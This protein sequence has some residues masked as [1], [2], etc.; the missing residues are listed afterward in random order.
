MQHIPRCWERQSDDSEYKKTLR[1]PGLCPGPRWGNLQRSRK[2]PSWWRGVCCPLPI[3]ASPLSALWGL[4]SST[5]TP[6]L[7]PTPMP[8]KRPFSRF[9]C[10]SSRQSST[11]SRRELFRLHEL[12]CSVFFLLPDQQHLSNSPTQD[13]KAVAQQLTRWGLHPANLSSTPAD[14]PLELLVVTGRESGQNCYRAPVK[15]LPW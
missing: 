11:N 7:V 10:I 12:Q 6:K 2:P 8:A 4:T 3:T 15:F 14:T 13:E 9:I 5:P 1:R